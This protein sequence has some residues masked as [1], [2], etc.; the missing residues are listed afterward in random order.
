M[1]RGASNRARAHD[2]CY[3]RTTMTPRAQ[4]SVHIH[5]IL[6]ARICAE[7]REV[8]GLQLTVPQASRFLDLDVALCLRVFHE[9]EETGFL[10]R[11]ADGR[12]Q[13]AERR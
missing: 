8:P 4:E 6:A 10:S 11:G 9:L 2:P 5:M 7:F 12:Y 1:S 3:V 13:R